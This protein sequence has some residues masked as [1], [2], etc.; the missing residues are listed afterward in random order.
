MPIN[1]IHFGIVWKLGAPF[2]ASRLS[3]CVDRL[4]WTELEW[5]NVAFAD[6]FSFTLRPLKSHM[7]VWRKVSTRYILKN[8]VSTFKSGFVSLP[9]PA[10]YLLNLIS[11]MESTWSAIAKVRGGASKYWRVQR[12][13]I[14][15]L[16]K[17]LSRMIGMEEFKA[18]SFCGTQIQLYSRDA[19]R[20]IVP[21]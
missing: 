18:M 7:R 8:M 1:W 13:R 20:R 15:W 17:Y 9:V 5:N 14:N 6:E 4:H 2:I 19:A 11:S 12:S 16:N 10:E 21:R 3:W